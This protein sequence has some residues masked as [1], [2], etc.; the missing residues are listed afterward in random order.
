MST[1]KSTLTDNLEDDDWALVIGPDGE[2]KGVYI[3]EAHDEESVPEAI[4]EI[5]EQY[6]DIDF[7]DDD[8]TN[9]LARTVH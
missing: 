7:Y 8:D 9:E 3:P 4:V 6:Y 1:E 5:L 2:L